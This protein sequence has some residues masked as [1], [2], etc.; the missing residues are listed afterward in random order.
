MCAQAEDGGCTIKLTR[1]KVADVSYNNKCL[2]TYPCKQMSAKGAAY[3]RGVAKVEK[4]KDIP[5]P[6]RAKSEDVKAKLRLVHAFG[7]PVR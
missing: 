5:Y 1:R 6:C 4:D 7:P 2:P 3:L